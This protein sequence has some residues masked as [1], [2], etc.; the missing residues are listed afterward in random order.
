MRP[1]DSN[2][3]HVFSFMKRSLCFIQTNANKRKYFFQMKLHNNCTN[4]NTELRFYTQ[5]LTCCFNSYVKCMFCFCSI[6]QT[7]AQSLNSRNKSYVL[8]HQI[9]PS[10]SDLDLNTNNSSEIRIADL[11]SVTFGEARRFNSSPKA[12]LAMPFLNKLN[13]ARLNILLLYAMAFVYLLPQLF[14]KRIAFVEIEKK[15]YVFPELTEFGRSKLYRQLFHLWFYLL[16]VYLVP[17]VLIFTFNFILLRA[18]LSSKKRCRRYIIKK[19]QNDAILR[20]NRSLSAQNIDLDINDNNNTSTKPSVSLAVKSNNLT[21]VSSHSLNPPTNL[22]SISVETTREI[23]TSKSVTLLAAET[24]E[25]PQQKQHLHPLTLPPAPHQSQ[26][27]LPEIVRSNTFRRKSNSFKMTNRSR[28]LTLTLFGVVFV[29]AI[30]HLP[31][32]I[33]KVVYVFYPK[34][35]FELNNKNLLVSLWADFANFLIM[36]NS[37]INFMLYIVF[38]P[39]RFREVNFFI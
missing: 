38:G 31:A 8:S 15:T 35:E 2:S 1:T 16:S 6:R 26:H 9:S 12:S 32:A 25:Q 4:K 39:G 21:V 24:N 17:F 22:S 5:Y 27:K 23:S 18:F 20:E 3:N 10:L 14:E 36:L 34:Y 37:S 19:E 13:K 28:S 11:T 33:A 7:T 29:F 30:C